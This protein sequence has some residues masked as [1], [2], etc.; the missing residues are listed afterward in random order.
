MNRYLQ[1][2][3]D[4]HVL[5][6]DWLGNAATPASLCDDLLSRFSPAFTMVTPAGTA[7]D[8]TSLA[9]F[10]RSQHGA[11]QGLKIEIEEMQLIAEHKYGATVTYKERQHIPGQN[12]TCRFSTVVFECTEE[13]SMR[14][15]HLH[16]TLLAA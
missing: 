2:V 14:W 9:R 5:I 4:A 13:G 6:G 1:E 12:L 8:F 15:R 3:L 16:E 7:L 11:R 10:F